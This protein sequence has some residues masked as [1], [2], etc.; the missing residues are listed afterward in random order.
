MIALPLAGSNDRLCNISKNRH[1]LRYLWTLFISTRDS[2]KR[3]PVCAHYSQD[4]R[5]TAQ[6][7][8]TMFVPR[9]PISSNFIRTCHHRGYR[10]EKGKSAK[11]WL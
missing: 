5:T 11:T 1:Q 2:V 9:A 4:E 8:L 7:A 6:L 10:N 3:H